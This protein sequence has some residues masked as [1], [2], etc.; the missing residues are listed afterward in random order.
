[1]A[2]SPLPG[3]ETFFEFLKARYG[4]AVLTVTG[5]VVGDRSYNIDYAK[6]WTIL[7][8]GVEIGKY[9]TF[10]PKP[11]TIGIIKEYHGYMPGYDR[12]L[13]EEDG[14]YRISLNFSNARF[15]AAPFPGVGHIVQTGWQRQD[16]HDTIP[17]P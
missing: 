2:D 12:G 3:A 11:G 7:A 5:P 9:R 13:E 17:F 10:G 16:G 8:D 14:R 1:M 6:A 4:T 15:E